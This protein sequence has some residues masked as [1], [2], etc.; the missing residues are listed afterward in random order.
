MK[1]VF[2]TGA[3]GVEVLDVPLPGRLE[4]AVLVRNHHSC[5]SAGTEGAAV[6]RRTGA[7][8]VVE[9]A[10]ASGDRLRQVWRIAQ[11]QG[12]ANT[13]ALVRSK[14]NDLSPLGYTSAGVVVEI[15]G[16]VP[17]RPGDRVACMG[18]G[19][20]S[21]A[22]YVAVPTN[23]VARIPAEVKSAP[24]SL[25]AL[26]CIAMQGVRR[27]ELEPGSVVGVVGLGL[28][29]QLAARLLVALGYRALGLDL[30]PIRVDFAARTAGLPAWTLEDR[31]QERVLEATGGLGLDGVVVCAA[32]ASNTPVNLAFDL[33]RQRG[34]V[35]VVGDVGLG[36][37]RAKMYA[38]ELEL[39]LSCSY[40]PGRYDPAYEEWGRDYP[41]AYVRFTEKRNLECYLDLLARGRLETDSLISRVVPVSEAVSAYAAIKS[42]A[43][44]SFAV[45]LDYGQPEATPTPPHRQAQSMIY[46]TKTHSPRTGAVRLGLIGCGGFVKVVHLPNLMRLSREFALAGVASRTGASAAAVAKRFGIS[47]ASSDHRLLLED[48]DIDAV[49]IGTRHASHGR[50]VLEALEAGKHVFVEKPLC[51]DLE[52]G[53]RIVE[54]AES[55]GLVVR[56]GF[57][58]R[59]APALSLL[60]QVVGTSGRR[61]LSC[62]VNVG[63]T[64][65][66][67][68]NTAAEGGRLV[69]EG[70]H[71]FDLC[72]WFMG[73]YPLSV[74]AAVAGE[75]EP[76]NSNVSLQAVYPDG[77][78]AT[79]LYT[80]LGDI[81]T[82]KEY[83]EAYGNGRCAKVD[84]YEDLRASTKVRLPRASRRNKGHLEELREFAAAVAG[85]SHPI[86]GADARAGLAATWMALA[87]YESARSGTTVPF[88]AFGGI[89]Q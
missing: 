37:D 21:H 47:R 58:R 31:L 59:F 77:S 8:G 18:A 19:Y 20:A 12:L 87:A 71:F 60:R 35:S 11:T 1:Q 53:R 78:L 32:A 40:G 44:D 34:R 27:L 81:A 69:G 30:S 65:G 42:A 4:G 63:S 70:V 49:L 84:N 68:S 67:W 41:A 86:P 55:S 56:V 24:A 73:V 17:F 75:P 79:L 62:R 2:L 5:I 14:L 13:V 10:L 28:I 26:A 76:L 52:T 3:G 33:C 83:F 74:G 85:Q 23:L 61:V 89:A 46:P 45:L 54:L 9:K 50:L 43:P 39:R 7:L 88:A 29:G 64:A 36:L 82:G 22:E 16:E 6:T 38:K 80:S 48:P 51:L 25:A 66:D 57:N 15:S 72:N